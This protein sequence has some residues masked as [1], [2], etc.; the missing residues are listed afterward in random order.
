M[1]IMSLY[2]NDSLI[3]LEVM[4][5]DEDQKLG[6]PWFSSDYLLAATS[7]LSSSEPTGKAHS[8]SSLLF[9]PSCCCLSL[10]TV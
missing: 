7:P 4:P 8:I 3:C 2:A 6:R 5:K 9:H 10:P 1:I